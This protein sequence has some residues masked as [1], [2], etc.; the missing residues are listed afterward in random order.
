MKGKC[1]EQ[2]QMRS[3]NQY[4]E[5]QKA[6]VVI[7]GEQY[8]AKA[9]RRNQNHYSWKLPSGHENQKVHSIAI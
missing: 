3:P 2:T 7:I 5:K 9:Q 6:N 4:A 1:L 8:G